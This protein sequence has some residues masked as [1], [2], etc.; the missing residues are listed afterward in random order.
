MKRLKRKKVIKLGVLRGD[1]P[2]GAHLKW[3]SKHQDIGWDIAFYMPVLIR[4]ALRSV[5]ANS[6][7][8][9]KN[10]PGVSAPQEEGYDKWMHEQLRAWKKKINDL[11]DKFDYAARVNVP[12]EFLPEEDRKAFDEYYDNLKLEDVLNPSY[13]LPENIK[14]IQEKECE[15]ID[16]MR[17]TLKEAFQELSEIWW[18]LWD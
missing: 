1:D 12:E 16:D 3:E 17:S 18:D 7:G 6:Y 15:I 8:F 5:A 11:A 13:E 2:Y 10:F 4:D 14:R 9:P